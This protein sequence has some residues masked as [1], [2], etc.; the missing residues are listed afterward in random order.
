MTDKILANRDDWS[1]LEEGYIRGNEHYPR[2]YL[3]LNGISVA[4]FNGDFSKTFQDKAYQELKDERRYAENDEGTRMNEPE[5]RRQIS[6]DIG[7]SDAPAVNDLLEDEMKH[8]AESEVSQREIEILR[9]MNEHGE[10]QCGDRREDSVNAIRLWN[11]SGLSIDEIGK[12]MDTG[13]RAPKGSRRSSEGPNPHASAHGPGWHR[14][15]RRHHEAALRGRHQT[16]K[17]GDKK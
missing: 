12:Q 1:I 14:E 5:A 7:D 11:G 6:R 16:E 3:R 10:T 9:L 13:H 15:P 8:W 17:G 4:R 2:T